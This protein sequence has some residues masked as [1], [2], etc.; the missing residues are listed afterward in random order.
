MYKNILIIIPNLN[1]GGIEKIAS[2]FSI[3]LPD[4]YNQYIFS[5]MPEE[6]GHPFK[7]KP[8][9]MNCSFGSN[10]ITKGIV[11]FRRLLKL[12]KVVKENNIDICISFGE[13]CNLL[14]MLSLCKTKRILTIHSQLSIENKSRGVYGKI[15]AIII[16]NLY[17]KANKIVCVAKIVQDDLVKN[18]NIKKEKTVVIYNGHN[19]EEIKQKSLL[20]KTSESDLITV[21]RIT[22]AKGHWHVLRALS[23]VKKE[24]PDIKLKIVGGYELDGIGSSLQRIIDFYNLE[25]NVEF[26]GFDDNPYSH[27]IASKILLL[28][29]IY[30]GFPGVVI[31]ALTLNKPVVTSDSGGATEIFTFPHG[32]SK[33]NYSVVTPKF[34][35]DILEF[36]PFTDSEIEYANA[37]I[38]TLNKINNNEEYNFNNL[39]SEYSIT[40][41]INR[42]KNVIDRV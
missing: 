36:E 21:G 7:V 31:E 6:D 13:R 22:Y 5:T 24:Y 8:I 42:Y 16:K 17:N 3:N 19:F 33:C 37:I 12:R 32:N 30:E 20:K 23:I 41:M 34:T 25:E 9:F 15:S 18:F 14:S 35:G 26:T 1:N 40:N 28:S 10:F 27:I 29:S 39:I 38:T 11:F 2:N 4:D